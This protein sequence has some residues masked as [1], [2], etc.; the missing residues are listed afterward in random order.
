GPTGFGFDQYRAIIIG[1]P[2]CNNYTSNYLAAMTALNATKAVWTPAAAGNVI[3]E[4]VDNA[5]H[6]YGGGNIGADKTVK[7][8]IAFAVND[9]T[10]TGFYYAVSCYYDYTAPATNAT[11]LPQLNGFGT[12]LT[13]NYSN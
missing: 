9:P 13:R 8:G 1:D 2:F 10:K 7:R 3:I 6:A 5:G 12:F 11:H 4:G